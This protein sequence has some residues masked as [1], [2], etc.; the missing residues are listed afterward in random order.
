MGAFDIR[1]V[2][3][4]N[5]ITGIPSIPGLSTS[6]GLHRSASC[7]CAASAHGKDVHLQ[8]SAGKTLNPESLNLKTLI[9]PMKTIHPNMMQT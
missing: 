2:G 7:Q 1:E 8:P 6:F 9:E 3:G 4:I 5:M